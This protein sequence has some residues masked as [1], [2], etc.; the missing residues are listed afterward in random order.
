V[1]HRASGSSCAPSSVAGAADVID[2]AA[3]LL[4]GDAAAHGGRHALGALA[5]QVQELLHQIAVD[6]A[7]RGHGAA[8]IVECAPGRVVQPAH[9]LDDA[10]QAL[11]RGCA[12]GSEAAQER[13]RRARSA[14]E[15][16]RF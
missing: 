7:A 12:Q 5:A 15:D 11:L 10:A 14:R 13:G 6:E 3:E 16:C 2:N 8:V 9:A 4:D 1:R